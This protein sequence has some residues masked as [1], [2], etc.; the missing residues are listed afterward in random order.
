[1]GVK[2]GVEKSITSQL[3]CRFPHK[4]YFN[5]MTFSE[6]P[7][8]HRFSYIE[9]KRPIGNCGPPQQSQ[10][11]V[12]SFHWLSISIYVYCCTYVRTSTF[13]LPSHVILSIFAQ[14]LPP[15]RR[16]RLRWDFEYMPPPHLNMESIRWIVSLRCRF[17]LYV[18][19]CRIYCRDTTEDT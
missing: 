4:I 1:M 15:F 7:P 6:F 16:V 5:W 14:N 12:A 9:Y 17:W 3:K 19:T 13:V 10:M 2:S 18:A 11:R 8:L